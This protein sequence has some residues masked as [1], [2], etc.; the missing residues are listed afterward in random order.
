MRWV[1]ILP[2]VT[3]TN[4]D[5]SPVLNGDAPVTCT[6]VDFLLSKLGHSAFT[7]TLDAMARGIGVRNALLKKPV[8]FLALEDADWEKLCT[9]AKDT[10]TM[11]PAFA[12]NYYE[13]SQAI[14]QAS[15]KDPA[16]KK[17]VER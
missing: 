5:G 9:S 3:I 10:S 14:I 17:A 15:D 4:L 1:S 12:H 7:S 6:H 2:K 8:K 16:T 13:F 11:V